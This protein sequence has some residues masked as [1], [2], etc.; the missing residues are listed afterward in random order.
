MERDIKKLISEMTLEEKVSLCSGKDF[1]YT[2]DIERLGIPAIMMADGPHGLRKQEGAS[3]HMGLNKSIPATCFPSA[4]GLACSWDKEIAKKVGIALGEEAQ[5]E[6]VSILLGPGANIKRSPLCGRNFEYFSED[7]FLSSKMATSF[8]K[9]VQSQG[10]GTSLK[11]FAVNNQEHRRMSIDAIVDERTL[12]EIYLASFEEPVKEG[13]PWTVMAAYNKVNGDFC[14]ENNRL[15]TE[16]LRDEWGF[17]DFVVSDWGAVVDR[18]RGVEAGMDVEM[19]NS[20]GI[21]DKKLLE[22]V[23]SGKLDEG[24]IDRALEK[25][26]KVVFRAIENKKVNSVYSKEMH[27]DIARE[28]ARESMVLLKN[29]DNILPLNDAE[30]IAVIGAFAKKPRYQGGGSSHINPTKIDNIY[31]ELEKLAGSNAKLTYSEGYDLVSDEID[32]ELI[33]DA[34]EAAKNAKVAV[35]FVGLP[36]RYESEGFDRKHLRI[37]DN[38]IKLIE[39][40][41][42]VQSNIVVVLSNGAPI[43]MPWLGKVKAVL[44]GYL[45]GQ[46]LGGAIADLLFGVVSPSGKLAETF[47]KKLCHNPS[48]LN[49]PGDDEK[50]EYKEGV[51]VGYRHYDTRDI[52]PLFPFG[53]GLSYSSFEYSDIKLDKKSITDEQTVTVTVKVKNTGDIEAKEI[54]QLYVKDVESSISRPE[55]ELKGFEKVSLKPGEEKTVAFTLDKRAFAYYNVNLKDWHIETGSFEI[56]VGKSSRSIVLRETLEVQSTVTLKKVLTKHSTFGDLMEHPIGAQVMKAMTPASSV[57]ASAS[58]DGLG[59]DPQEMMKGTVLRAAVAM[60]N[61]AF[62]EEMLQGI[63]QA[64]NGSN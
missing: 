7:P 23:K 60:S 49:F 45:G 41:A 28:V 19:P 1:W 61:G 39:A 8:I 17:E 24:I 4:A 5:A 26:L 42:E 30:S 36:D 34:K 40:V 50:V 46:A 9:G 53:Y 64:V 3:D 62:T 58:L 63:L 2:R 35:I 48:Y 44:E 57:D 12:R 43:E 33:N 29:E 18:D 38:H 59:T 27:H 16:I 47:P 52:E 6:G 55:K 51:F 25:V 20:G 54:V 14:S 32:K 13:K 10:V 22:A 11:H 37:P 21:G 31:E 56:L 15:L